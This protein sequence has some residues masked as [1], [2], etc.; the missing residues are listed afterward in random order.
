MKRPNTEIA[1]KIIENTLN[2]R[3]AEITR[4]ETGLCHYVYDVKTDS[5]E[6]IVIR[7]ATENSIE[8]LKGGVY[9]FKKLKAKEIPVPNIIKFDLEN[10]YPYVIM[11]RLI[12]TDLGYVYDDLSV[13]EKRNLAKEI[14]KIQ[15][16]VTR[17]P[18]AEGYGYAT[19]YDD[20]T[21]E[22]NKT[23]KE[24]IL[25][26]L[27]CSK[28]RIENIGVCSTKPVELLLSRIDRYDD[29]FDRRKPVPF[30]DDITTKNVIMTDGKL[31]GIV[32]VDT[33]CFGDKVYQFALTKM[34]LLS[35]KS[36]TDYIDY[37]AKEYHLSKEQLEV[38]DFYTAVCC[39]DFISEI[40]QQFNADE[41]PKIDKERI[42]FLERIFYDLLP[43]DNVLKT[44]LKRYGDSCKEFFNEQIITD[45]IRV[46]KKGKEAVVVCCKA[47][48]KMKTDFIAVKLYREKK[49]R[50]FKKDGIYHQGRIW[51]KR[52][53]R[54]KK[55]GST[56]VKQVEREVWVNNE[57]ET[58]EIL[59]DLGLKVP[60]PIAC[61]EDAVVM[62]FI[63]DG[64]YSAPLL[65]EIRFSKN[66]AEE[67]FEKI[68]IN[69][70]LMLR[71]HIVH[72]DL[73]PFNI[74]YHNG[75]PVII[76]FPQ[77][78]DPNIN[79]N[80]FELLQRDVENICTFVHKFG[81]EK[82]SYTIS[83]QMWEPLYG[84]VMC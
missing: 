15:K 76:D 68:V 84:P 5:G 59:Y 45:L 71:N 23:W 6:E 43:E 40:G 29:Y 78:V 55:K 56:I 51:D 80:A 48:P 63:G 4:F 14:V 17:M 35:Q 65:K 53:E 46:V 7:I 3:I 81:V 50:N 31:N 73:S 1:K 26:S 77:A 22:K 21:L 57:Y 52:L 27:S 24:V 83:K 9:W 18:K 61:T 66:E 39:V 67:L 37:L 20:A 2:C 34:A 32:D 11:E 16:I 13:E 82:D 36:D 10:N 62:S 74:L 28:R 44:D 60:E 30:L 42:A 79:F 8:E 64:E 33:I 69:I 38:L 54:G 70:D 25:N 75:E 41:T 19:S 58:L 12:G 47:H 49:F 72:G